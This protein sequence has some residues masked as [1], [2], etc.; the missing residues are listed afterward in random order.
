MA[1]GIVAH[2][3]EFFHGELAVGIK[4]G[5]VGGHVHDFAEQ[6]FRIVVVAHHLAFERER[7]F[8]NERGVHVS[9]LDGGE[10]RLGELVGDLV[11]AGYAQV[12]YLI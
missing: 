4:Y 2:R 8:R 3:R 5:F 10:S 6:E 1:C 7:E 12:V 9:T 11:P